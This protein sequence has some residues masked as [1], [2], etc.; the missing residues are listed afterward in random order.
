MPAVALS[1]ASAPTLT[2]RPAGDWSEGRERRT[3][4]IGGRLHIH[5]QQEL[6]IGR[7][8]VLNL[9]PAESARDIEQHVDTSEARP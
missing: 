2:M 7:M 5:P 1:A 3:Y 9:D 6:E 8:A 4:G